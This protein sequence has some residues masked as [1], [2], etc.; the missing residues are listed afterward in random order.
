M[1]KL[2]QCALRQAGFLATMTQASCCRLGGA[3]VESGQTAS[4]SSA[5]L[6]VG[7]VHQEELVHA[8]LPLYF[9]QR[10]HLQSRPLVMSSEGP[11][12]SRSQA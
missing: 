9:L 3:G 1:F 4:P 7:H 10:V 6:L 11:S 2:L 5:E 12:G 8:L